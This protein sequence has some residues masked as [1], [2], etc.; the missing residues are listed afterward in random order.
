MDRGIGQNSDA[1]ERAAGAALWSGH[2]GLSGSQIW[3]RNPFDS[4]WMSMP[5]S[6]RESFGNL[7]IHGVRCLTDLFGNVVC[8]PDQLTHEVLLDEKSP[9]QQ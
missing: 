2:P 6:G 5:S 8:N 9:G 4:D 1:Q 7:A 3:Y